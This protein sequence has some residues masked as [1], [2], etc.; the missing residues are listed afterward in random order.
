MWKVVHFLNDN[1]V[2]PVPDYWLNRE[3]NLCAWPNNNHLAK[4][5][6]NNRV[7]PNNFDFTNYKCRVLSQNILSLNEAINKAN[8]AEYTSELSDIEKGAKNVKRKRKTECLNSDQV[9]PSKI[10]K[11][12]KRIFKKEGLSTSISKNQNDEQN[13]EYYSQDKNIFTQIDN[14]E[15]SEISSAVSSVDDSDSDKD[16]LPNILQD[17][18]KD[19]DKDDFLQSTN[20]KFISNDDYSLIVEDKQL[21]HNQQNAS[22]INTDSAAP[23]ILKPGDDCDDVGSNLIHNAQTMM[24]TPP[25]PVKTSNDLKAV[26]SYLA[27]IKCEV[28]RISETQQEIIEILNNNNTQILQKNTDLLSCDNNETDYFVMNWPI[29]DDD[30]LLDLENKMKDRIF[31]KLVV[32]ELT[33]LGGKTLSRIIN[34]M[35]KKVFDDT[36]LIKF[37]YYGLRNK[38]NFHTLSINKAIFDAVRKSKQKSVSDEEIIISIGKYMTGAKGRIE[39]QN[40]KNQ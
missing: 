9:Q 18:S 22:A 28:N 6:R 10:T 19:K 37:T 35:L 36:I 29:T 11:T 27:Y 13:K 1:S 15:N 2:E 8:K 34:K 40:I 24:T 3:N 7:K 12:A 25:A 21:G 30:G 38:E 14:E 5:M 39:Q 32:S 33:R 23:T 20:Y 26:M 31:Y 17:E 4:K 16:Y